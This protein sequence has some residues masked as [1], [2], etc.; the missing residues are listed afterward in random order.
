MVLMLAL[1]LGKGG[2]TALGFEKA[3]TT[4]TRERGLGSLEIRV[5][6]RMHPQVDQATAERLQKSCL[7]I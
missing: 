1:K 5:R 3:V 2:A 6:R 7:G 4:R